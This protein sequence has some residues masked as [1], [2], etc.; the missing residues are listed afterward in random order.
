MIKKYFDRKMMKSISKSLTN[1]NNWDISYHYGVPR[2]TNGEYFFQLHQYHLNLYDSYMY[3]GDKIR[4]RKIYKFTF[5]EKIYVNRC[6]SKYFTM[7][8]SKE[9]KKERK[10][11]DKTNDEIISRL[12]TYKLK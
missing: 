5:L 4:S 9:I 12:D 7:V 2:L 11:Y 6:I 1:N 10:K 3:E 8:K